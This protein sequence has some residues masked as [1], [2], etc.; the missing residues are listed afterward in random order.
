MVVAVS[1]INNFNFLYM[2]CPAFPIS[3]QLFVENSKSYRSVTTTST[4]YSRKL[5]TSFAETSSATFEN[6]LNLL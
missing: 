5:E 3:K 1:V 4:A 6:L 2:S